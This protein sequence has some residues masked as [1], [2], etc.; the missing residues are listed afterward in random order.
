MYLFRDE[1]ELL[2]EAFQSVGT[3]IEDYVKQAG[4][5]L[6]DSAIESAG[7]RL[8][9]EAVQ[10]SIEALSTLRSQLD[11]QRVQLRIGQRS[12]WE[13]SSEERIA[14]YEKQDDI[15]DKMRQ[16]AFLS[17]KLVRSDF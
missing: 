6:N 15:E 4:R 10:Q 13:L 2:S 16:C 1:V 8:S 3:V 17:E 9:Q 7:V 5:A 11:S 14:A 12:L